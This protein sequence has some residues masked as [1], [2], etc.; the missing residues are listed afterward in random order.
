MKRFAFLSAVLVAWAVF[1]GTSGCAHLSAAKLESRA[2]V[3]HYEDARQ[4]LNKKERSGSEGGCPT[5]VY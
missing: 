5:C 2:I 1:A 4:Q 3:A